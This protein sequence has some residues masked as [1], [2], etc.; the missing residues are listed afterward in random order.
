[1]KVLVKQRFDEKPFTHVYYVEQRCIQSVGGVKLAVKAIKVQAFHCCC[2]GSTFSSG[3]N[4]VT[5][6]FSPKLT[7]ML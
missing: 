1:M 3:Y 6:D 7:C 2:W 4:I 5:L